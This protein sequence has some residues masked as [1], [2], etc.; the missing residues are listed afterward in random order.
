MPVAGNSLEPTA[1]RARFGPPARRHARYIYFAGIQATDGGAGGFLGPG[2]LGVY[3]VTANGNVTPLHVIVGQKTG[4]FEGG[5]CCVPQ[6]AWFDAAS[7]SIWTCRTFSNLISRFSTNQGQSSWGNAKPSDTLVISPHTVSCGGVALTSGGDIV[8]DD[9][10]K[11]FVATWRAGSTGES[12]PIRT[13][14]G[15]A[16]K[17][18]LPSQIAFDSHGHYIVSDRCSAPKCSGNNGG[19]ILIFD[20]HANGN[21]AP[22][23]VLAGA[24][25]QLSGPG[26]VIYDATH[27]VIY[28]AN[29]YT[30][31]ITGYPAGSSGNVAPSIF[32]HGNKTQLFNPD[33]IAIDAD[34]YL[35]V[36]NE[37]IV[38]GPPP[39]SIEVFAPGA[40]GNVAP[41]QIIQGSKTQLA[42]VNGLSVH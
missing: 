42:E 17:L 35:Y 20:A 6:S 19:A 30:S 18:F 29:L 39:A 28:V 41:V 8:A 12:A 22:L 16:T 34:G 23:R 15:P 31:T 14:A 25:T 3:P 11:A 2:E 10:N 40:N 1:M 38:P 13:I 33:A 27:N 37:P 4:L 32:I 9:I 21:A 26:R 7:S 5:G 36:G 24:K